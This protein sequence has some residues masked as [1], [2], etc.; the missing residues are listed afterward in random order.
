M[1]RSDRSAWPSHSLY[2]MTSAAAEASVLDTASASLA[3]SKDRWASRTF[4]AR[5]FVAEKRRRGEE[6]RRRGEERRGEPA[7]K[8][9]EL[10]RLFCFTII[11]LIDVTNFTT[12]SPYGSRHKVKGKRE[13]E[14]GEESKRVCEREKKQFTSNYMTERQVFTLSSSNWFTLFRYSFY[15]LIY[16]LVYQPSNGH[17]HT[18]TF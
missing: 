8:G 12:F 13:R 18:H 5:T 17:T 15:P 2:R 6:K 3:F 11:N 10:F 4:V 16:V 7:A 1:R 14:I 9:T